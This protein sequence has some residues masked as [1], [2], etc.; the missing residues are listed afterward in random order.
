MMVDYRRLQFEMDEVNNLP[1]FWSFRLN[2]DSLYRDVDWRHYVW[3]GL[4]PTGH[5]VFL[6]YPE[7]YPYG[8][9]SVEVEPDIQ[10]K[11]KHSLRE[12]CYIRGYEWN[13]SFTV[14]SMIPVIF[15]FLQD[16]SKG[17]I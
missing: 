1:H 3:I 6:R 10:T 5:I 13:P 4:S 11:Y 14:V 15:K 8:F 12:L 2:K 7:E 17:R 16:Y 9:F